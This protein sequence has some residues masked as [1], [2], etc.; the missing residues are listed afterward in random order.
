MWSLIIYLE[1]RT[2]EVLFVYMVQSKIFVVHFLNAP[3]RA[4]VVDDQA[5][6]ALSDVEGKLGTYRRLYH[7]IYEKGLSD[8]YLT[9]IRFL[10]PHD[11]R[12]KIMNFISAKNLLEIVPN[13]THECVLFKKYLT[14]I[15]P[16]KNDQDIKAMAIFTKT[17]ED[18]KQIEEKKQKALAQQLLEAQ[19]LLKQFHSEAMK[20]EEVLGKLKNL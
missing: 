10:C 4:V 19:I 18:K 11:N 2:E 16:F 7:K 13:N 9:P 5:H 17:A 6:F 20:L 3:L 8:T 1:E 14:N 12:I 15:L